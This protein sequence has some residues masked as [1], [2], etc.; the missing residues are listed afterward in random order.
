MS[1]IAVMET[2]EDDAGVVRVG[3]FAEF[4]NRREA[5]A[6]VAA[7]ITRFPAAFVAARPNDGNWFTWAV[8]G[9]G[10]TLARRPRQRPQVKESR[11]A[12]AIRRIAQEFPDPAKSEINAILDGGD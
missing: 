10:R 12:R 7:N 4:P 3:K 11:V 6:H 5:D 9:D 2:V 1:F 8:V